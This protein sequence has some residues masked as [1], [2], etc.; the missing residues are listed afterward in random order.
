[1]NT[2]HVVLVLRLL[3]ALLS[4]LA[5]G[6]CEGIGRELIYNPKQGRPTDYTCL[7]ELPECEAPRPVM[8]L[9]HLAPKDQSLPP[10]QLSGEGEVRSGLN[11]RNC[12]LRIDA[13]EPVLRELNRSALF[14]V[15]I[16]LQGTASLRIH[17]SSLSGCAIVAD[18]AESGPLAGL[19]VS[20]STLTSVDARVGQLD[21]LSSVVERSTLEADWLVATDVELKFSEVSASDGLFSA[22]LLWFSVIPHCDALLIA[23][24]TLREVHIAACS[25]VTRLYESNLTKVQLDGTIE[26]DRAEIAKTVFGLKNVTALT[27]YRSSVSEVVFCKQFQ[28]LRWSAGSL[29][30]TDCRGPLAS[31]EPDACTDPDKSTSIDENN[32]CDVLLV[33]PLCDEFPRRTRPL[34]ET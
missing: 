2:A 25:G 14:Q 33:L 19:E 28:T 10:C 15:R 5:L 27:S 32:L 8:T 1:M 21:L 26:A 22:S 3:G 23:G 16:E 30:C 7:T 18:A 9:S 20:H 31:D 29:T 4:V 6:A 17:D 13:G 12:A 24:S 34:T 11:L